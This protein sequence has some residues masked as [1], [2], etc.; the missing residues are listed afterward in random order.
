MQEY[1][2][3]NK[4]LHGVSWSAIDQ[5]ANQGVFFVVGI[6]LA[7]M[8][9]PYDYG[10]IGIITV[11]VNV[12]GIFVNAGFG[13]G[14]VRK[15]KV[16]EIDYNTAFICTFSISVV[17]YLFM[18]IIAPL[19]A[20]F[21]SRKELLILTRVMS[22]LL[23]ISGITVVQ[24]AI[25]T[26]AINFKLQTKISIASSIASSVIGISMAYCSWGVWSLVGQQL[27]RSIIQS[28]LL[29]INTV[30]CPKLSFS[31]DSFSYLWHFGWKLTASSLINSIFTETYQFVIGKIYKPST[32]GQY[33]RALQF[34]NVFSVN[35]TSI[36]QRVAVPSLSAIQED[37]QR[38]INLL[39]RIT[40]A[41]MSISL[42]CMFG[43]AVMAE[44]IVLTL[45]GEKWSDSIV[46][47]QLLCF[48]RMLY[49]LLA[50]SW[51]VLQVKGRSD[52]ILKIEIWKRSFMIIP[53]LI[54]VF[55]NIYLMIISSVILNILFFFINAYYPA[56][57][58]GY[59]IKTQII[60]IFPSFK[61]A[62]VIS[63]PVYFISLIELPSILLLGIQLIS[64]FTLLI[65][66]CEVFNMQEYVK[67]KCQ[68]KESFFY[69]I[70][71]K[72]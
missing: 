52:L 55:F 12:F 45:L 10:L 58:F 28:I 64:F 62:I 54:G 43:M 47:L 14:L 33:T 4:I 24:T 16:E 1:S 44:P 27:T 35:F 65:L 21:F 71:S 56:R 51:S 5:F 7:R 36:I 11:F 42:L 39:R 70:Q 18:W 6:I 69:L 17:S 59:D 49:P 25:L 26:R 8:L 61:M 20:D 72:S 40:S 53:I 32:L 2:L 19:V 37:T 63:V 46:F 13:I 22:L 66:Y 48:D 23:I 41:S 3:K 15:E 38:M 31:K 57:L 68:I 9:T 60:D 29:W 30:W 34:S 50:L 67:L